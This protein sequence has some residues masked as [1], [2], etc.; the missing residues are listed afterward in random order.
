MKYMELQLSERLTPFDLDSTLQC[1]Q[2][3]RW[4]K[5]R[6]WWYCI[7][8]RKGVKI[9]QRRHSLEFEN[10]RVDF[11][12]SYFRLDDN[13]PMIVSRI[14]QDSIIRQATQA[15]PGLRLVRQDPWEC[16]ISFMCA[17]FKNIPAI[18]SMITQLSR[19]L[20]SEID[21]EGLQRHT[22]PEPKELAEASLSELR[23]C[24]LGFRAKRIRQ[25][26]RIIENHELD[27]H[28]L[29]TFDYENGKSELLQLPGVGHK[30]ADCVLLFSLEK[31]EAFPVDVW[32]KRIVVENYAHLLDES[33]IGPMPSRTL[34][35]KEYNTISSFARRYFGRHAGYAQEYLYHFHRS[36]QPRRANPAR[37]TKPSDFPA[38]RAPHG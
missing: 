17:T 3:F 10:M 9:R 37:A 18:R 34:S 20:G 14:S 32:I 7:V 33:L 8:G 19:R 6:G 2:L 16:L 4:E 21:F 12:K 11:L 36:C 35:T 26:A 15:F 31:L 23:E 38:S 29:Q 28:T 1:G 24:G 5:R 27:L 22:F 25:T 30:V 13:L